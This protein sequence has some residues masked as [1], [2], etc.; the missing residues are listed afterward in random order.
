MSEQMLWR[1]ELHSLLTPFRPS[2]QSDIK[3]N[4]FMERW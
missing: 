4:M 3:M 2:N 1:L